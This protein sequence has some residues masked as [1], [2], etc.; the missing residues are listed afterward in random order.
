MLAT[1]P[2]KVSQEGHI[3]TFGTLCPLFVQQ[4]GQ[5]IARLISI[6]LVH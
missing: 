4:K 3:S 5:N 2:Y 6:L 1:N